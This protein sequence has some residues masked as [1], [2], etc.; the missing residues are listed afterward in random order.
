MYHNGNNNQLVVAIQPSSVYQPFQ[1]ISSEG[2]LSYWIPPGNEG[3]R[4]K[5]MGNFLE[6]KKKQ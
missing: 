4:Q 2:V 5:K 1:A 6:K 3:S